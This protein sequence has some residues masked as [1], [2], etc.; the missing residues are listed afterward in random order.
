[1]LCC[2]LALT[3]GEMQDRHSMPV[4]QM[5]IEMTLFIFMSLLENDSLDL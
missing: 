2:C 4:R 3:F 1:M 5:E